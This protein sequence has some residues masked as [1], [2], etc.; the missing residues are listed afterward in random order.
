ML[1]EE[2]YLLCA[3]VHGEGPLLYSISSLEMYAHH[4]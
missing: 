4:G 1:P 2:H 3:I